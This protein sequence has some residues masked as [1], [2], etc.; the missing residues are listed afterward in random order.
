MII[1]EILFFAD[2]EK[3]LKTHLS[4]GNKPKDIDNCGGNGIALDIESSENEEFS[5]IDSDD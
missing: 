4:D 2:M 3:I 1:L 5:D